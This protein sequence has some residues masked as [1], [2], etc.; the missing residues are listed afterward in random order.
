[1]I[2]TVIVDDESIVIKGLQVLMERLELPC[3]VVGTAMDGKTALSVI[4]AEKPD[5]VITDIRIPYLDGLSL[6][7]R[8]RDAFGPEDPTFYVIISGYQEFEYARKALRLGALDYIDK[9]V[10]KDKLLKTFSRVEERRNRAAADAAAAA[11]SGSV[12]AGTAADADDRNAAAIIA[13][14]SGQTGQ[15]KRQESTGAAAQPADT[16]ERT[17]SAAIRRILH[18]IQEN[19]QKDIGLTEL[20]EMVEMNPAYL[21]LLFKEQVGTS[22]VKYLTGLRIRRAEELLAAGGKP[23]EIA[24]AI[25]YNDPRYFYEIFKR[26][27]GMTPGEYRERVRQNKENAPA[28]ESS[29]PPQP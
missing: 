10:T 4:L 24:A 6:I 21:S 9:P 8:C 5:L 19:Y 17:T 25:G 2:R 29:R 22:F 12:A 14:Q 18:Y 20:S 3:R 28:A 1:M 26:K 15:T 23:S 11:E 27:T 13:E 16:R 7:E